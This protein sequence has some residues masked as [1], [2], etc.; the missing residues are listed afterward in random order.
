MASLKRFYL[1]RYTRTYSLLVR[2]RLMLSHRND[3]LRLIYYFTINFV[4]LLVVKL[5]S[6]VCNLLAETSCILDLRL[7]MFW[8]FRTSTSRPL[9][10]RENL[11]ILTYINIYILARGVYIIVFYEWQFIEQGFV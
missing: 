1:T 9:A 8:K 10:V 5:V 6:L 7:Q 11:N 4:T 2:R 3:D